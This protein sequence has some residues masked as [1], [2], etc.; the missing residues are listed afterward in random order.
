[1]KKRSGDIVSICDASDTNLGKSMYWDDIDLPYVKEIGLNTSEQEDLLFAIKDG[2]LETVKQCVNE[3][4]I[5]AVTPTGRTPLMIAAAKSGDTA[6]EIAKYLID[7]GANVSYVSRYSKSALVMASERGHYEMVIFLVEYGHADVNNP[8]TEH[9]SA[10]YLGADN[11][12]IKEY[13]ISKG[14]KID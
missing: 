11:E 10:A 7:N 3:N 2:D 5:N 1:M 4:T 9:S 12:D 6:I 8:M 14:A 13:L